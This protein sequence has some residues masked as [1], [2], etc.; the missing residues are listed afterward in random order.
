MGNGTKY[1]YGAAV[2]G[3]QSFI[4]QTNELK[5]IVGAS[6]LVEEICTTAF[7]DFVTF[8]RSVVRAAGNI[9]FIFE[10]K[11]D[12]EKAV[13]G[14]PKKVM[15]MAPGITISQ[16]VV[17]LSNEEEFPAAIEKLESALRTQR[18]K[19]MRSNTTGLMGLERSRN[20]GLPLIKEIKGDYLDASTFAK[21]YIWSDK[22]K[23]DYRKRTTFKLCMKAFGQED[24]L[25]A[26]IAYNIEDITQK[27]DW[28]AVIHADGN[29][30]GQIVQK[31]GKDRKKFRDFSLKLDEATKLS[32][33]Q[34]YV[35]VSEGIDFTNKG[36][37]PIRPIVLGGDDFTAICRGDIALDYVTEF[38]YQFEQKTHEL[39]GETIKDNNVFGSGGA[40]KLTACAGIAFIKSSYPF[41]YGYDLADALCERAKKDAKK[42][43]NKK[44]GLALSCLMF[45]KVQDSF[46]TN[47]DDIVKRELTPTKDV[48]FEFG[49]YYIDEEKPKDR[50]TINE[51]M[52]FVQKLDSK[53]GNAIKSHLRQWMTVLHDDGIGSANQ[54]IKRLKTIVNKE[55]KQI[56]ETLVPSGEQSKYAV[57]D[58]L[59]L[60]SVMNQETKDIKEEENR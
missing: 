6:E 9:K 49:P 33:Q 54:L 47:F 57:Y 7:A 35:K 50:W 24:I 13:L 34:A 11:E 37:I 19:P 40:D 26:N 32:A 43:E 4:F 10:K 46:V 58:V 28:I 5:D 16:A 23:K 8:G 39:L 56:V 17:T 60:L 59:S 42:D 18:N 55:D 52:N 1:L 53:E 20:T 41:Y 31:I 48:S 38:L 14:F 29:G 45:H 12:C 3:I 27:N 15:L 25:N 30:L 22:L 21:R 36:I 2:Q 44:R 51:L